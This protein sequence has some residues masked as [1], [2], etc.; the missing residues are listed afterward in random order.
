MSG[1]AEDAAE[2][3]ERV[4]A[5]VRSTDG[6]ELAEVDLQLRGEGTIMNTAQK[7]RSDLRLA[8]LR[9]DGELIRLA[10]QVAEEIVGDDPDLGRHPDLAAELD[11]M[12][13]ADD[14][15]FSRRAD[16][17]RRAGSARDVF[18]IRRRGCRGRCRSRRR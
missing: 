16:L 2:I 9:H 1:G 3:S 10:R 11:V 5:L 15:H 12:L 13:S 18:G 17:H 4:Q 8:S 7:G 14:E 6:F